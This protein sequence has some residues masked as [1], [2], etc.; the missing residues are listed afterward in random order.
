MAWISGSAE[1]VTN[2]YAWQVVD[3]G[4][5]FHNTEGD[6]EDDAGQSYAAYTGNVAPRVAG[7]QRYLNG[8]SVQGN[9]EL[10]ISLP[11]GEIQRNE[12]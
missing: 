10:F 8:S 1:Q 7:L 3:G 2:G 4:L 11:S 6:T 5:V 12:G 9:Q